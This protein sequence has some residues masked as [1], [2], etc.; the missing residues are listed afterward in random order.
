MFTGIA[1]VQTVG[2]SGP[3]AGFVMDNKLSVAHPTSRGTP[4]LVSTPGASRQLSST[5][6]GSTAPKRLYSP[7][8][9]REPY[10]PVL[11]AAP[12]TLL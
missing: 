5:D 6:L 7:T 9:G 4:A 12:A 10:W 1:E 2:D 3:V 11:A 8:V